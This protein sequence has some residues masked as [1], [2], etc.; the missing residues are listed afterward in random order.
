[1]Y[2]SSTPAS[3]LPA[4]RNDWKLNIGLPRPLDGT[5]VLLDDVVQVVDLAHHHRQVPAGADRLNGRPVGA[6][7]SI[8][9]FAGPPY[10]P[11]ALAKKRFAAAMLRS[12]VACWG[13]L[14]Q[15]RY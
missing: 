10:A 15:I 7:L 4:Q 14:T 12:S 6:L 11:M 9:A 8:A 5:M 1:M 3:T 13:M 2:K